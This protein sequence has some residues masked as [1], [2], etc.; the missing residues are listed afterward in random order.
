MKPNISNNQMPKKTL[1]NI[2]PNIKDKLDGPK[3]IRSWDIL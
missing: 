1:I 2:K 3:K